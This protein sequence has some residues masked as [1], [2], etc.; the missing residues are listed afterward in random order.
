MVG[1]TSEKKLQKA[2]AEIFEL[3][4]FIKTEITKLENKATLSTKYDK[5]KDKHIVYV[6][7][8]PN[9]DEIVL[10][11]SVIAG[12]ILH[13]LRSSLDNLVFDLSNYNT[14]GLIQNPRNIQFP[15]VDSIPSNGLQGIA[16]IGD[17]QKNIIDKFQ[18]YHGVSGRP[19]SYFG[20]YIHQLS[21]LREYS[22]SDKHRTMIKISFNPNK[23]ELYNNA[24]KICLLHNEYINK[25]PVEYWEKYK[26]PKMNIGDIL[27]EFKVEGLVIDNTE[28]A[29]YATANI[30][31][32][33]Y[34]PLIPT[35]KRIHSYVE[36]IVKNLMTS[37]E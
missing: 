20:N 11:I 15:I 35:L 5:Q 28:F 25:N 24:S 9:F 17:N 16:E 10:S 34:G 21:L 23:F 14:N 18:P 22:N 31:I 26:L 7:S 8:V 3:E 32:A 30:S 27:Y 12:G 29:G 6:D 36:L 33:E 2:K 1:R 37:L 13:Y 19:D 4:E